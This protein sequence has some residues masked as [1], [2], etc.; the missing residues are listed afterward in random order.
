MIKVC[1]NTLCRLVYPPFC[2]WFSHMLP[3]KSPLLTLH[4]PCL[5]VKHHFSRS[6]RFTS[7]KPYVFHEFH[8][9]FLHISPMFHQHLVISP[10][11]FPWKKHRRAPSHGPGFGARR[12]PAAAARRRRN[13][14]GTVAGKSLGILRCTYCMTF[15][16]VSVFW[17]PIP[18]VDIKCITMGSKLHMINYYHV[19]DQ[20]RETEWNS[21]YNHPSLDFGRFGS[22]LV[23]MAS[24]DWQLRVAHPNG[25][26]PSWGA[27]GTGSGNS[28]GE[29]ESKQAG[30]IIPSGEL[31]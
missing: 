25:I 11:F 20:T 15:V 23:T 19:Y 28:P 30:R 4:S 3:A 2:C 6:P 12:R 14:T 1:P 27:C 10:G 13:L 29:L 21:V 5:M 22:D 24:N 17:L 18:Y 31:T 7:K 9:E 8:G 26:R 16:D